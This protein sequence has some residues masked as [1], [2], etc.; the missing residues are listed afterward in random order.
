MN[1][2]RPPQ[3]FEQETAMRRKITVA[4][5]LISC[6]LKSESKILWADFSKLLIFQLEKSLSSK[7]NEI[8]SNDYAIIECDIDNLVAAYE[9]WVVLLQ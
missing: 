8:K 7:W 1:D 9:G 3:L 6:L 2:R 4:D 5:L